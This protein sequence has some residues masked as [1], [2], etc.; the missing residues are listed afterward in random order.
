MKITLSNNRPN[1]MSKEEFE[2]S[3]NNI[4]YT[5]SALY[6]TLSSMKSSTEMVKAEDFSVANHYALMAFQA[7]KRAAYEEIIGMLP[8][9]A[10][11]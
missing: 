9:T 11:D 8:K 10:L 7:G 1:E 5:L 3:W 4:G 6:K 2:K